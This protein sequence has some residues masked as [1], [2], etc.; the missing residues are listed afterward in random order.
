LGDS[1]HV[2]F[3]PPKTCKSICYISCRLL[4]WY[5]KNR[6]QQTFYFFIFGVFDHPL[7]TIMQLSLLAVYHSR[8]EE[9]RTTNSLKKNERF[10]Y[11]RDAIASRS[12]DTIN[13]IRLTVE[14][15]EAQRTQRK[16]QHIT[17]WWDE[18]GGKKPSLIRRNVERTDPVT[19]PDRI[20]RNGER[21]KNIKCAARYV[22][23]SCTLWSCTESLLGFYGNT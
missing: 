15:M 6:T 19:S 18:E 11:P 17:K 20:K 21:G 1:W 12:R 7:S 23:N 10:T 5:Q 22:C 4:S 13:L 9:L 14:N 8:Q 3:L 16:R 2:G